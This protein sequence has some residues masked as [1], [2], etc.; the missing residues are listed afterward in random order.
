MK[1]ARR[2]DGLDTPSAIGNSGPPT[3]SVANYLRFLRSHK[4]ATIAMTT[5]AITPSTIPAIA[6]APGVFLVSE[7][8]DAPPKDVKVA[9]GVVVEL[10][11]FGHFVN[12]PSPQAL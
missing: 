1:S 12:A 5:A 9:C 2:R 4:A 8:S 6:G 10:E 7:E 3:R 11:A